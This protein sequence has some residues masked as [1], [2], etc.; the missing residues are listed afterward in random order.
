MSE[1]RKR[2]Q[3]RLRRSL[4]VAVVLPKYERIEETL[5]GLKYRL[6]LKQKL[7]LAFVFAGLTGLGAQF[8][9]PL[10]F[11]PVPFTLQVFFVLL[12]GVILGGSF[13]GLSQFLYVVL[14]AAGLPWFAGFRAGYWVLTGITGG[15]LIGFIVAAFLVGWFTGKH[16]WMKNFSAQLLLMFAAI[17]V[18]YGFGALWVW[19]IFKADFLTTLFVSVIPFIPGDVVK[20]VSAAIIGSRL[21][22]RR[23]L[24]VE[25]AQ[26][27]LSKRLR[28]TLI[29]CFAAGLGLTS[30]VYITLVRTGLVSL[31]I[32]PLKYML[33][34]C[35]GLI[36]LGFIFTELM[37]RKIKTQRF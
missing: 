37:K 28:R 8:R 31:N 35:I 10:P 17:L 15:Y 26:K 25:E 36:V 21:A 2:R 13:G 22:S 34:Y 4:P 6:S 14:G 24:D 30:L 20:A 3:R 29:I 33:A 7:A 27:F 12:S 16:S 19:M 32:E 23:F 1:E 5:S 11:T 9:V 18:I